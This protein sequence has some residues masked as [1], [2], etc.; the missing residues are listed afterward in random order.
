MNLQGTAE[1]HNDRIG[2][3][4]ASKMPYLLKKKLDGSW[5]AE[6]KHAI[7]Q[8]ARERL[9]G[10]LAQSFVSQAML[11][12][13]EREPVARDLFEKSARVHVIETGFIK[14]P[15]IDYFGCSPDGLY[16]DD[17]FLE[18]KCPTLR[19]FKKVEETVDINL[20]LPQIHAQSATLRRPSCSLVFY[21]PESEKLV[22]FE[23]KIT[24]EDV[25]KIE[26]EAMIALKIIDHV[27]WELL[28][29]EG[30]L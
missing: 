3:L 1:W 14:H 20:Y 6:R 4:T 7:L 17:C 23:I 2:H 13:I 16:N 9:T 22:K 29:K 8:I 19:T 28:D 27:F 5:A 10:E 15:E 24:Q 12:G 26:Y 18:I 21:H 11:D 30:G 25:E